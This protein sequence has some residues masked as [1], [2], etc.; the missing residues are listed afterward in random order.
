[1]FVEKANPPA[2]DL[3]RFWGVIHQ[4]LSGAGLQP[5]I[6]AVLKIEA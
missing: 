5:R 2:R 6:V 4:V 3:P 1:M